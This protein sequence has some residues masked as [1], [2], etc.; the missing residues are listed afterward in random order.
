M[1]DIKSMLKAFLGTEKRLK[2]IIV[3]LVVK[4]LYMT[5]GWFHQNFIL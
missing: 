1:S 5:Y 4:C 3:V 2:A